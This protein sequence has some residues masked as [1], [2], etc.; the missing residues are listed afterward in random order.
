MIITALAYL[1]MT[2]IIFTAIVFIFGITEQDD[3]LILVVLLSAVWPAL[4]MILAFA[5]II[6]AVF[7]IINTIVKIFTK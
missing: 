1:A 2:A 3:D 6:G 4:I 5:C 7:K